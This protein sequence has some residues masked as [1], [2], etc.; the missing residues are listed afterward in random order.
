M[1]LT[2]EREVALW[3]LRVMFNNDK[4]ELNLETH[5]LNT[6]KGLQI[7]FFFCTSILTMKISYLKVFLF[8]FKIL[9]R[10]NNDRQSL[11]LRF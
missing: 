9:S 6:E 5:L 3:I 2:D 10:R 11:H 1:A 7:F 4:D 8:S